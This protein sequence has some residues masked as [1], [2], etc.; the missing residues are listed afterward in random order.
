[1]SRISISI[2]IQLLQMG[3]SCPEEGSNIFNQRVLRL[4]LVSEPC[5]PLSAHV[6]PSRRLNRNCSLVFPILL[7]VLI[8]S[9]QQTQQLQR[10]TE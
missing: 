10:A 5:E 7:K 3:S 4:N 9:R 6:K 1:M 8:K 2:H